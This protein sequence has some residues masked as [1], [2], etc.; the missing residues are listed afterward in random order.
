MISAA[1]TA[2]TAQS[3][4][5]RAAAT[6]SMSTGGS[7]PV[8]SS[9]DQDGSL[10]RA[11]A[12]RRVGSAVLKGGGVALAGVLLSGAPRATFARDEEEEQFDALRDGLEM[13]KKENE[14]SQMLFVH[15]HIFCNKQVDWQRL[16]LCTVQSVQYN[17]YVVII[18]PFFVK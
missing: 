8:T 7:A 17:H 3:A 16:Q 4:R 10:S 11:E 13:K 1:S 5:P 2:T 9:M 15:L 6:P 18:V 14:V 12:V